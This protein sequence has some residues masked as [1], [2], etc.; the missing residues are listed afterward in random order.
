MDQLWDSLENP[1]KDGS[2]MADNT[3]QNLRVI[4]QNL[5]TTSSPGYNSL[6]DNLALVTEDIELLIS[7]TSMLSDKVRKTKMAFQGLDDIGK[8]AFRE[9]VNRTWKVPQL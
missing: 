7:I 3:L 6:K 2:G 5:N 9:T 1:T 4:R 8:E